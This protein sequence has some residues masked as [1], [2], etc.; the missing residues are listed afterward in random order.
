M[1]IISRTT[2]PISKLLQ[3][4]YLVHISFQVLYLL[5]EK[6]G[7]WLYIYQYKSVIN[8]WMILEEGNDPHIVTC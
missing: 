1:L 5:W 2:P 4:Q 7:S 3:E 6:N 8:V